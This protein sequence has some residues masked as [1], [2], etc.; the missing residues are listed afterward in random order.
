MSTFVALHVGWY[1]CHISINSS[2]I[3][4]W[5]GRVQFKSCVAL[6][7][8]PQLHEDDPQIRKEN[9]VDR[10]LQSARSRQ[11]RV[12]LELVKGM[13][14]VILTKGCCDGELPEPPLRDFACSE[15]A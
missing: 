14:S 11:A 12:I 5:T 13:I 7:T 2:K 8:N 9:T 15:E 10:D 4:S 6:A 3:R 1:M